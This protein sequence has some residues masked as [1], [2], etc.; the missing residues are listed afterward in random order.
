[1]R[2]GA[3]DL[4]LFPALRDCGES[5]EL[6]LEESAD[7]AQR[8][9][10]DG[11][12]RLLVLKMAREYRQ[13]RKEFVA[14]RALQL[15]CLALE[16][17]R[18]MDQV[19]AERV[20]ELAFLPGD[21]PDIRDA[22]GFDDRIRAGKGS[23]FPLGLE[24]RRALSAAVAGLQHVRGRLDALAGRGFADTVD[25]VRIQTETLFAAGFLR[26]VSVRRLQYYERYIA[27]AVWRLEKLEEDPRRDY[28]RLD[29]IRPFQQALEE[30][31]ALDEPYRSLEAVRAYG[32]LLQEYRVSVFAQH[33]G[34]AQPASA[35]RLRRQWREARTALAAAGAISAML[36]SL[37][38][39]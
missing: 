37:A 26:A 30:L 12:L 38:A 25:D 39:P 8:V 1:M 9:T 31:L 32:W 28:R 18:P 2:H 36:D 5:V 29:E 27:A 4:R 33:L 17:A 15:G 24:L 21:L 3:H 35:K 7:A 16:S 13:L 23:V 20:F 19:F 34:T 14:D 10:R 22:D 11:V 6:C